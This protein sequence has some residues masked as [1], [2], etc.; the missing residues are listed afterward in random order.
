MLTEIQPSLFQHSHGMMY[1]ITVLFKTNI[2]D[3]RRTISTCLGNRR[4]GWKNYPN[5]SFLSG[6]Q[7]RYGSMALEQRITASPCDGIIPSSV[8][9][10][11]KQ[12]SILRVHISQISFQFSQKRT[13]LTPRH[14]PAPRIPALQNPMGT[15]I[16]RESRHVP[17]EA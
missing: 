3:E 9:P 2:R 15:I 12:T 10:L 17:V 5:S 13:M 1:G 14:G 8:W 11:P 6:I 16:F 4:S 7:V